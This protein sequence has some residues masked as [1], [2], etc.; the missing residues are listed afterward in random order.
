NCRCLRR[1][2]R[3]TGSCQRGAPCRFQ[4]LDSC[5]PVMQS[6]PDCMGDD[7]PEALD[8]APVRCI[9]AERNMRAPPIIIG[10]AFRKN[11][12]QVL[13]VEHDQMIPTLAGSNRSGAQHG[14]SARA[15]GMT[16]A[17]PECPWPAY[18]V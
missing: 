9:L 18:G 14:R 4:K 17:S 1:R 5:V 10:G 8:R 16:L 13:C 15:S 12:P 2:N 6:D 3:A 11:L 7:A